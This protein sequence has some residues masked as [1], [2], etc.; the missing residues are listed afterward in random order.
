MDCYADSSKSCS[1]PV[2]LPRG[3]SDPDRSWCVASNIQVGNRAREDPSIEL[4][5]NRTPICEYIFSNRRFCHTE[6]KVLAVLKIKCLVW[7]SPSTILRIFCDHF[8]LKLKYC[9][10]FFEKAKE[11]HRIWIEWD[12]PLVQSLTVR[13]SHARGI[14]TAYS[15]YVSHLH[16]NC[17]M[18]QFCLKSHSDP[19]Y[20]EEHIKLIWSYAIIGVF[21]NDRQGILLHWCQSSTP[22]V[23]E[24]VLQASAAAEAMNFPSSN[25]KTV[26]PTVIFP[27]FMQNKVFTTVPI[28]SSES[29]F[30]S[31]AKEDDPT[32]MQ[33][34]LTYPEYEKI[35]LHLRG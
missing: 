26:A 15:F 3:T 23:F 21:V 16:F 22:H 17:L 31:H 32:L 12:S 28:H 8:A 10:E 9:R 33:Y 1:R 19:Y 13:A 30:C 11:S 5:K 29:Y 7:L 6:R 27:M 2:W 18:L 35:R 20:P 14:F 25:M 24:G 4:A 34:S